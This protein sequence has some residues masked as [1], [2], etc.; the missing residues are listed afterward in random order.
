VPISGFF[1][2]VAGR[3]AVSLVVYVTTRDTKG[4]DLAGS[5]AAEGS[6][7]FTPATAS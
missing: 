5:R 4:L 3:G 6:G 1:R 7:E 2:Y